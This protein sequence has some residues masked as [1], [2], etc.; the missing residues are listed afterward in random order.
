MSYGLCRLQTK[1]GMSNSDKGQAPRRASSPPSAIGGGSERYEYDGF[2]LDAM[3]V[4]DEF[5]K[6]MSSEAFPNNSQHGDFV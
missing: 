2:R 3:K 6:A 4:N 1:H 5:L